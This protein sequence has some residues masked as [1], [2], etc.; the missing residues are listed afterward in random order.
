MGRM[1]IVITFPEASPPPFNTKEH[2]RVEAYLGSACHL[3]LL[4]QDAQGAGE[5]VPELQ[6]QQGPQFTTH[7]EKI[8]PSCYWWMTACS[9]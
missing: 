1:C 2:W 6:V 5:N 3:H 8:L 7:H 4:M 9:H